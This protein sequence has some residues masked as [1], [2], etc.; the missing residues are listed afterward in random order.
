MKYTISTTYVLK[1]QLKNNSEY[2]FTKDGVCINTKT[3]NLIK[4]IINN[5]SKG[6]CIKG[7]FKSINTLRKDLEQIPK[8][9]KLPF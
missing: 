2:K 3:G 5:R 8:K 7:K 6:Y 4:M 9:E 1:W